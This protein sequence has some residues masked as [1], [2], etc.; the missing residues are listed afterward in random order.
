MFS[1]VNI[2]DI[3]V[4][5]TLCCSLLCPR[6]AGLRIGL[7][8]KQRNGSH[9]MVLYLQ[10]LQQKQRQQQVLRHG[11]STFPFRASHVVAK[12]T[13]GVAVRQRVSN[14][15]PYRRPSNRLHQGA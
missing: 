14:L 1:F 7:H 13:D 6:V 4:G 10:Q 5:L 9:M 11:N 8:L 3:T 2:A 15:Q 12:V